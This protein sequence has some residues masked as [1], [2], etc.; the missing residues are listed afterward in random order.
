MTP[1]FPARVRARPGRPPKFGRPSRTIALTLPEDVISALGRLD[2]DLARA[3]VRLSQPLVTDT[4]TRA[5]VELSQYHDSAVIVVRPSKALER[6]PG[7]TLVP[8]P[9]GRALISLDESIGISEFE[10]KLLYA[11]NAGVNMTEQDRSIMSSIA[12]ILKHSRQTRDISLHERSIIVL[13]VSGRRRLVAKP[14]PTA[15]QTKRRRL[16]GRK[17]GT[18]K[19]GDR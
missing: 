14:E 6:I 19:R 7:V 18:E 15:Q 13:K 4:A 12:E 3:V 10:L 8:L 11:I 9:D 16:Q 17:A 1:T 5:S 2:D